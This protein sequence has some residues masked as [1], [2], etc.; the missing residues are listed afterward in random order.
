[1]YLMFICT[2]SKAMMC[3]IIQILSFIT[4][5]GFKRRRR[6]LSRQKRSTYSY[7]EDLARLTGGELYEISKRETTAVSELVIGLET[8]KSRVCVVIQI[9]CWCF[10]VIRSGLTSL[11]PASMLSPFPLGSNQLEHLS[12]F[13]ITNSA[14]EMNPL[15]VQELKTV[16]R[17][18]ALHKTTALKWMT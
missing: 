2:T 7:Y 12:E 11:L 14:Q 3:F 10:C 17:G 18:H 1:M 13:Y 5:L 15:L 9:C 8:R 16:S 6:S 4:D